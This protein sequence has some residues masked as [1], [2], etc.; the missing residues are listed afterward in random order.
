MRA[1]KVAFA[2]IVVLICETVCA[3]QKGGGVKPAGQNPPPSPSD[4]VHDVVG[5][6]FGGLPVD[7]GLDDLDKDLHA[8]SAGDV[9]TWDDKSNTVGA[10]LF[11]L[12]VTYMKFQNAGSA[13]CAPS[14]SRKQSVIFH[15]THWVNRSN[16][17]ADS[18]PTLL[19]S[20]WY[21]YRHSRWKKKD[22]KTL[23]PADLTG[24]GDPLIYGASRVLIVGIDRFDAFSGVQTAGRLSTTYSVTVAQGTPANWSD[25]GALIAGLGGISAQ[26]LG[27]IAGLHPVYVG[28][29]CQLGT[30]NLPFSIAISETAVQDANVDPQRGGAPQPSNPGTTTCSGQSNTTPCSMTR[31]FTSLDHEYWD[32]SI[33]IATPGLR[34]TT[35]S[36]SSAS[37]NVSSSVT[38]HTEAY[39]LVD[40]FP[41]ANALPKESIVPHFAVGIPV[42]SKSLYRPFFGVSENLTGW[43]KLQKKLNLPVGIN[44]LAGIGFMKT[45]EIIGSPTSQA[46]FQS[47]LAMHRVWK[48]MFGF[49]VPVASA[50][51]KLAGGKGGSGKG[52]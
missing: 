46:Q 22:D 15:V 40:I 12:A 26:S 34:E 31:T 39:G 9:L 14:V 41:F 25:L 51:S 18:P 5:N 2:L 44:F 6:T 48:P 36:F 33:G 32:V 4:P 29:A 49:E 13:S 7:D 1:T 37:G 38:T 19:S 10:S 28:A 27:A 21:V 17:P 24:A 47:A 8:L 3:Q 35:Y 43:T 16:P 23:I 52:K 11:K 42:A 45:Q 50:L 20:D 30:A